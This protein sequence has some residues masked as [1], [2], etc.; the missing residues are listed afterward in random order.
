MGR[1]A[2]TL[3]MAGVLVLTLGVAAP[4]QAGPVDPVPIKGTLV[5]TETI[6]PAGTWDYYGYFIDPGPKADFDVDGDGQTDYTCSEPAHE[7]VVS[8]LTGNVSHLGKV[9]RQQSYCAVWE[10]YA[11]Y[12]MFDFT[13]VLTAAN[14]DTLE[15]GQGPFE[16]TEADG[17]TYFTV[18]TPILGGTGRFAGASGTL[19]EDGRMA[20]PW[21]PEG[22]GEDPWTA[23]G[24]EPWVKELSLTYTRG[25]HI[26]YDA[27]NR[28][29]K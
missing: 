24:S 12:R 13:Q 11:Q 10:G 6:Y 19:Y 27:S 25:S 20:A 8:T 18:E 16:G 2:R 3:F 29:A 23:T 17:W 21:W 26:T 9:T 15:L 7:L 22:F 5:G 4:A 28:A 14:G 1:A